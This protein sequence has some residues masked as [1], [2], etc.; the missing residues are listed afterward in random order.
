[1]S[2]DVVQIDILKMCFLFVCIDR[3]K[4][5]TKKKRTLG[6]WKIGVGE[7][8]KTLQKNMGAVARIW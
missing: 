7:K 1:M 8:K 5:D 4:G 3:H 2:F 6:F